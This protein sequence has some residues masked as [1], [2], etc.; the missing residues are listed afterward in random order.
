MLKCAWLRST[1][2]PKK[3]SN[4]V[5]C[6]P[7]PFYHKSFS[8]TAKESLFWDLKAYSS[9]RFSLNYRLAL[10]QLPE[11]LTMTALTM[12]ASS[13]TSIVGLINDITKIP[14]FAKQCS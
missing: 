1:G 8:F 12:M 5:M 14:A 10:Q 13:Y 6:Y 11:D 7:V 9:Q 2:F 3:Q 4:S